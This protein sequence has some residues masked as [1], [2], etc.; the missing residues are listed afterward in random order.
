MSNLVEFII[1][2]LFKAFNVKQNFLMP[3]F[4]NMFKLSGT[5][6]IWNYQ[7]IIILALLLVPKSKVVN[8]T[9]GVQWRR[10]DKL[11]FPV[12]R[13]KF[14]HLYLAI[15][16]QINLKPI[17]VFI[18]LMNKNV[19]RCSVFTL[20]LVKTL[21]IHFISIWLLF[22]LAEPPRCNNEPVPKMTAFSQQLKPHPV[23]K[24]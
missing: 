2:L 8:L 1:S 16:T 21:K 11:R 19:W 9:K 3:Q 17:S 20:S 10:A 24:T 6:S 4:G 22:H 7:W 14:S 23:P 13:I 12:N 5:Y 15:R 18:Y